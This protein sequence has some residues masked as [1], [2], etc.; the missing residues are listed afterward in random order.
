MENIT[1]SLNLILA[2][3][4]PIGVGKDLASYEY[5]IYIPQILKSSNNIDELL[6]SLEK[7]IIEL[8]VGYNPNNEK[9]TENLYNICCKIIGLIENTL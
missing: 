1:E 7:I 9:H 6:K 4:D 2:E 8:D 5:R 3:W